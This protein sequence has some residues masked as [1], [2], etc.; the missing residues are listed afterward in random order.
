MFFCREKDKTATT[1]IWIKT[2]RQRQIISR[3]QY[4]NAHTHLICQRS[5]IISYTSFE[6][7]KPVLCGYIVIH[8]SETF[9]NIHY[10]ESWHTKN[11]NNNNNS[12]EE[13]KKASYTQTVWDSGKKIPLH[14]THLQEHCVYVYDTSHSTTHCEYTIKRKREKPPAHTTTQAAHTTPHHTV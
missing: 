7:Y 11:N 9:T 13:T 8:T 2:N 4:T 10:I 5:I 3:K 1:K 6:C 12:S 14:L